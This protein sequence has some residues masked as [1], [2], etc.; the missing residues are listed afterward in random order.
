PFGRR[1][2]VSELDA[3]GFATPTG[4]HLGLHVDASAEALR[5]GAGVRRR[6]GDV[7]ARHGNTGLAQQR[8]SLILVNFHWSGCLEAG[9]HRGWPE[10]GAR[11]LRSPD[12]PVELRE[13]GSRRSTRLRTPG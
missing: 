3:A 11:R 6:S 1:R 9:A 2:I 7:A 4:V 10:V 8:L 5:D 12:S 13:L